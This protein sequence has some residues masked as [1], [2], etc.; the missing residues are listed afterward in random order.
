MPYKDKAKQLQAMR[1]IMRAKRYRESFKTETIYIRPCG[2]GVSLL[3]NYQ[4]IS[5]VYP[6]GTYQIKIKPVKEVKE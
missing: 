4:D 5:E 6:E 2:R 3:P 1:E